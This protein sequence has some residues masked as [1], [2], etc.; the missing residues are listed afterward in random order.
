LCN[1]FGGI[2]NKKHTSIYTFTPIWFKY[3]P[4]SHKHYL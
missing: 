3:V 2:A 4:F 1:A